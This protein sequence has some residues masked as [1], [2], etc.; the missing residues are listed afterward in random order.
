MVSGGVI[1]SVGKGIITSSLG[2]L[3]ESRGYKVALMKID[4][5]INIDA[6]TMRPTEHG[7]V[8]VTEDGFETDQD[9]GNYERFTTFTTNSWNSVT[10]GQI[11][12]KVIRDEREGKYHG[13]CVEVIPHI[14]MEVVR[15]IKQTAETEDADITLVEIGATAGEYQIF[16]FLD[17]ARRM[18][19]N[20]EKVCFVHVGY[21]PT[22]KTVGEQKSKPLQRSVMDLMSVGVMPD[23]V[24]CRSDQ[25]VD[26]ERRQKISLNCNVLSSHIISAHNV[27]S[28]YEVPISLRN[29]NFDEKILDIF[30]LKHG[31]EQGFEKWM[32]HFQKSQQYRRNITVGV[33]GKY[34]DFG[35]FK[36]EDSYISVVEALRHAA[37]HEDM[38]VN[39]KWLDSKRYDDEENLSELNELNAIIV[40]GG[41]GESGVN[42]K[43][44]AIKH[45]RENNIPFLGLC[46]GLQLAVVEYAR[47]VLNLQGAHTTEIFSETPHPVIYIM[48]DQAKLLAKNKFGGSM[49]L[50]AYDAT[51]KEGTMAHELYGQ[52]EIR[53]RHRHRYEVNNDYR[54]K[55]TDA[56]LIVSGVNEELDLVEFIELPNNKH[57]FFLATQAHPEFK[58]KFFK[59]S[60][61][62]TGLVRAALAKD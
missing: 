15:R 14:P 39:V 57:P 56:G 45:A 19:N 7:E 34:L 13:K 29:Q 46:Y 22:P 62:F 3:L 38:N 5:Y 41:F 35:D 59:P 11:Y 28:I 61:P 12:E 8:Y 48:P 44:N 24:V 33:V 50:G 30:G 52:A 43:I 10:T 37:W 17:A 36:V 21:L 6:G 4:P 40:P 47:N 26:E 58:S 51:L 31:D 18:K 55:L 53:E 25:P 16:P 60:P 42:G 20:G 9:L 32:A 2:Q 49:R 27:S 54:K 1:S 23:F